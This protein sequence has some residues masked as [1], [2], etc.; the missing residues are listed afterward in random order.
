MSTVR[1]PRHTE[2]PATKRLEQRW[3]RQSLIAAFETLREITSG[4]GRRQL[5][6]LKISLRMN[7]LSLYAAFGRWQECVA[8]GRQLRAI[9]RR[10]K[11]GSMLSAVARSA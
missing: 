8:K 10:L 9:V 4:S 2:Q 6:L 5:I 1:I 3:L 7:N 11:N